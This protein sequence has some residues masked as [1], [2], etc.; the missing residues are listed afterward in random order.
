MNDARA[1]TDYRASV[2]AA[3]LVRWYGSVS[4]VGRA[5]AAR[6]GTEPDAGRRAIYRARDG[7][8]SEETVARLEVLLAGG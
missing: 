8:A 4:A 1:R 2:V 3:R 6:F 7:E 5:Y